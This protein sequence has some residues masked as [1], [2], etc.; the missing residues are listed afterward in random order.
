MDY[1]TWKKSEK[2]KYY[3]NSLTCGTWKP[4]EETK[5]KQSTDA[6]DKQMAARGAGSGSSGKKKKGDCE[7]MNANPLACGDH[8]KTYIYM[9]PS[10]AYLD[11]IQLLSIIPQQNWKKIL[12][13]KF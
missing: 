1:T 10:H 9:K 13:I 4:N 2:D 11:H 5:E 8:F 12:N 7:A 3:V 6:G